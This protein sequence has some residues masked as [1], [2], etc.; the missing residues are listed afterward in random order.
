MSTAL[1]TAASGFGTSLNYVNNLVRK[2]INYITDADSDDDTPPPPPPTTGTKSLPE[3]GDENIYNL[4]IVVEFV[5]V[6]KGC[7]SRIGSSFLECIELDVI[8]KSGF[9]IKKLKNDDLKIL[10]DIIVNIGYGRYGDDLF[11]FG[12]GVSETDI[13]VYKIDKSLEGLERLLKMC[14]GKRGGYW[15]K[16]REGI[17]GQKVNLEKLR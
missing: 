13:S 2:S 16:K 7:D 8:L 3:L 15:G 17:R 10:E 5:E 11:V 14:E 1:S 6:L 9:S 12:L 4:N